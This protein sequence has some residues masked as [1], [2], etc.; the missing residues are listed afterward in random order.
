MKKQLFRQKHIKC[1]ASHRELWEC[2]RFFTVNYTMSFFTSKN[3]KSYTILSQ[4]FTVYSKE[5][6]LNSFAL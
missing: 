6:L 4:L 5:A 2:Q 1:E 3:S